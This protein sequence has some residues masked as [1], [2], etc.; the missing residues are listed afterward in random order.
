MALF[1]GFPVDGFS[2]LEIEE[3]E[4]IGSGEQLEG[5]DEGEESSVMADDIRVVN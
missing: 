5:T 2:R 1:V 4:F 3:L